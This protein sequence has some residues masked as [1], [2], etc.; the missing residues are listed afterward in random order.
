MS[1]L[2]SCAR[3]C[4]VVAALAFAAG[5]D[6]DG[7]GDL[8]AGKAAHAV[9][10]LAKAE[11]CFERSS[12]RAEGNPEPL[13][14][15]AV[16]KLALG[17]LDEAR[18]A[19]E[20]AAALAPGDGDIA[21]LDAQVSWHLKDYDRALRGFSAVAENPE[22]DAAM[23]SQGWSGIGV[24]EMSREN[25]HLSRIAFMRALR[26]DMRNL[27]ARYNLGLLYRDGFG[28][29]EAALEQFNFY[30]RLAPVA[31]ARVQKVQRS[32]IP[33]L[34]E[35][36]ARAAADRPGASVRNSSA[37]ASLIAKAEEALAKKAYKT[38]LLRYQEALKADALSYPAA[39]GLAKT[40]LKADASRDSLR[41][42]FDS[43][44]LACVLSPGS[45]PTFLAAGELATRL[46]F[47]AEAAN[48]Y[49]RALAASPSDIR[50]LN[51]LI[52]ALGRTGSG[53]KTAEDYRRY[54]EFI[55]PAKSPAAKPPAVKPAAAKPAV[56]KPA[57][58]KPATV[59]PE[60]VKPSAVKPAVAKPS[61]AKP[62]GGK[63]S[64]KGKK[65]R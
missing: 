37:C 6:R 24:V 43:Y 52:D 20:A 12:R 23:R 27:A 15:L 58:A 28:Y 5:C 50:A 30:V 65:N 59:K 60:A 2:E 18:R 45:L 48:L 38:A 33:E 10:D 22:F 47:N 21:L 1:F 7:S 39:L 17:K 61:S 19:T 57:V 64:G 41:K 16:V 62:S 4:A 49:S 31:D 26:L 40:Y 36:I 9:G 32:C 55:S 42:A 14:R 35:A 29:S 13:A 54:R 25:H 51:G 8:A 34:K 11:K 3:S 63:P 44:K 56:A 53:R 46:G